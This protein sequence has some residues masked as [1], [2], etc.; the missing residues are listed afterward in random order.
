MYTAAGAT[1]TAR[2]CDRDSTLMPSGPG[3]ATRIGLMA[4]E[5]PPYGPG[6]AGG[7]GA[8]WK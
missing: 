6:G 2:D 7:P 8:G 5:S 1:R 3:P 4:S